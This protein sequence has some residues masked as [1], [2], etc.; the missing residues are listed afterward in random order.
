MLS[1]FLVYLVGGAFAGLLAGL[2]GIGGGLLVVPL[3]AFTLAHYHAVPEIYVMHMSVATSLAVIVGTSIS[4]IIGHVRH[5]AIDWE[6]FKCLLPGLILGAVVGANVAD[7]LPSSFLR[8]IFGI[9]VLVIAYRMGIAK[10]VRVKPIPL[11]GKKG[12]GIFGFFASMFCDLLGMGGGSII[13]PYLTYHSVPMRRAV[14]TSAVCG[15][16]IALVGVIGLILVGADEIGIPAHKSLGYVYLPAFAGLVIP[17][18][19]IAPYGAKLSHHVPADKLRKI[20][21]IFLVFVSA[22]MLSKAYDDLYSWLI[23]RVF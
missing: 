10:K 1:E 6:I 22:D 7:L 15:F 5:G 8:V 12:L 13:V 23:M 14:S 16:P 4:S 19:I 2:L 9:F 18:I 17:S 11:P 20:F 21:A 3:L